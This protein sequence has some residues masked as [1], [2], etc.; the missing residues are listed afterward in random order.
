MYKAERYGLVLACTPK[1]IDELQFAYNESVG[2][3][4]EKQRIKSKDR[5]I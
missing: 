2:M 5:T 1:A 3:D 4:F